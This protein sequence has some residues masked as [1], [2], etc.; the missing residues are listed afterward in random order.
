MEAALAKFEAELV[1]YQPNMLLPL[2][3]EGFESPPDPYPLYT[4]AAPDEEGFI[5]T[6]KGREALDTEDPEEFR[7]HD[8][9][10]FVY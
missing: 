2:A 3:D 5:L 6:D 10:P 7:D 8:G 1:D 4:D 9:N